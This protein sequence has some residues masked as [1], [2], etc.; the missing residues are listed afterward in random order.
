MDE[1]ID[2]SKN[3]EMNEAL[4]EFEIKDAEQTVQTQPAVNLKTSEASKMAQWIM[5]ISG[6]KIKEEQQAEYILL[7]FAIIAIIVSLFLMFG[8]NINVVQNE[9]PIYQEDLTPTARAT[10]PEDILKTI[11]YKNAK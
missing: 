7:G 5:K 2:L 1:S 6:G 8:G 3:I 4:K 10:I 9:A 11:P